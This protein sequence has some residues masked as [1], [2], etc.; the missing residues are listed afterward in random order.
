[1]PVDLSVVKGDYFHDLLSQPDSLR[2]T[3]EQLVESKELQTLASRLQKHKFKSV[4]LTGMGSSF[5][6]LHPLV[7]QLTNSGYS[8]IHVETSELIY[9]RRRLL[10]PD[11]LL[12]VVSQSGRSIEMIRLL[13]ENHRRA[14]IIAVTNTVD[15]PLGRRSTAMVVTRAGEEYSVSCK[16]YVCALLALKFLGDQLCGVPIARTRK[17]LN[18]IL[19]PATHYLARWKEHVEFMVPRLIGA[20]QLFLVGRGPSLAAVGTGAL[21]LKESTQY[22]AEGLSSASFRHGPFE[23]VGPETFVLVFAGD[24]KTKQLNK[25]L[26]E[27]VRANQGCAEI[28]AQGAGECAY[29]LPTVSPSLLPVMEI[30]P[31]QM[32]TL[33]LAAING[34]EP[35]KFRLASKITT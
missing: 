12:V 27:D 22:P 3:L 17:E 26:F 18:S 34:R 31:V 9:Y 30:L 7:L 29:C 6:G 35:G 11:S 4:V 13:N 2:D 21:I 14:P 32:L 8:V 1:M 33:A 25:R 15:S 10:N 24:S 16:T 28:V 23:M 19:R 20:R 5:H